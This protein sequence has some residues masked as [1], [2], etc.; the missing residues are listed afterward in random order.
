MKKILTISSRAYL[1]KSY[2]PTVHY[3]E[4]WNEF[5]KVF[6][7][8]FEVTGLCFYIEQKDD[9]AIQAEFDHKA[10]KISKNRVLRLVLGDLRIAFWLL[11]NVRKFDIVYIRTEPFIPLTCFVLMF[12]FRVDLIVESNSSVKEDIASIGSNP[13]L[14][15]FGA[16]QERLQVSYASLTIAVSSGIAEYLKTIGAKNIVTINNG[17]ASKYFR[18]EQKATEEK[19]LKF[20]Y[21]G[22]YAPWSGV[23]HIVE[24]AEKFPEHE[25]YLYGEGQLKSQVEAAIKSDNVHMLGYVK[26]SKLPEIY[27]K[28]DA[29]IVLYTFERNDI[30]LSSIKTLEYM[31]CGLPIF[32]TD[33]PGQEYISDNNFGVTTDFENIEQ[34][35]QHFVEKIDFYKTK[36]EE[37]RSGKGLGSSWEETARKTGNAILEVF[38]DFQS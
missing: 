9:P 20:V 4:L 23:I 24:L 27:S 7:D 3:V 17:V 1:D 2:G 19:K 21:V 12:L 22:T 15:K 16:W 29:G 30:V 25:F 8:V 37:Y 5:S 36:A 11:F 13:L 14:T 26:Y 38:P 35:F 18:R 33:V 31:A 32:A 28:Y 6:K 34:N 10:F